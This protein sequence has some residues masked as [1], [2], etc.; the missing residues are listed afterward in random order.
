MHSVKDFVKLRRDGKAIPEAMTV[1]QMIE[2]GWT[3]EKVIEARWLFDERPV[4]LTN[5]FG[6]LAKV[7]PQR[8]GIAV[9][10]DHDD[11]AMNN[12]LRVVNADGTVR[13]VL[14]NHQQINGRDQA[15]AFAWFEPSRTK[16]SSAFGV[17]FQ[18][19]TGSS[20]WQL[21]VDADDGRVLA[22]YEAR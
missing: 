22:A 2:Q 6:L 16:V 12:E 7:L 18:A 13:F 4:V 5:R 8:D 17:V 15:G 19:P 10:V 3:P 9:I 1:D 20:M 11:T 21:D 14:A